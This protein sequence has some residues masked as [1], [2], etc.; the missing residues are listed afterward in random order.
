MQTG[1]KSLIEIHQVKKNLPILSS[2]KLFFLHFFFIKRLASVGLDAKN[3]VCI[4]DWRKGTLLASATGHSDRFWTL[5][6]N[7]LTAKRGI[8]GKTGDLQTILCLACAKDDITYS[9]AL[10]GD[11]YVWK[12]LTLVRTIQGAHSAGIFSMYACEEGFATGGRDGCIRLWDTDFKP[13][14]KIDLRETEQGYK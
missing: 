6:G 2:I 3:T 11:I 1:V 13:I 10:N 8:F 9:G 7:A 12:G 4:W 14:T 5:C